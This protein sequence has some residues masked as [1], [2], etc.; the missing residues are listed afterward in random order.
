MATA[1]FR[2]ELPTERKNGAPLDPQTEIAHTEVQLSA[3][4]GA[5]FSPPANVAPDVAQEFPVADLAGGSYVFRGVVVDTDGRRSDP[6]D[7]SF[8]VLEAPLGPQN[9][10][11]DVQN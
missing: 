1:T 6:T 5:N 10:T 4:G 8:S 9:A 3:D 2:W 7:V 11:V